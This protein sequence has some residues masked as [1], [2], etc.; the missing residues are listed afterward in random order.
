MGVLIGKWKWNEIIFPAYGIDGAHHVKFVCNGVSYN[1]ILIYSYQ[2]FYRLV[3]VPAE[4]YQVVM[5]TS[6]MRNGIEEQ[7]RIIDV[8]SSDVSDS[9]Y[10]WFTEN[11]TRFKNYNVDFYKH[12]TV[13]EQASRLPKEL[14]EAYKKSQMDRITIFDGNA[15]LEVTG[16]AEYSY[17]DEKSYKT[18]PIRNQDGSIQ[19]IEEYATFLTPRAIIKYSM[20]KIEDYR[21]I[22]KMLKSR[23]ALIVK[24]YD[25][26]E[27]KI[28]RNEMYVAPPSMPKIYQQYLMALGIQEYSLELIGTNVPIL[29]SIDGN[30]TREIDLRI[31]HDR[32]TANFGMVWREWVQYH[33]DEYYV[34]SDG[35]IG[36]SAGGFV[37]PNLSSYVNAE[38]YIL[39]H[40][41]Y[42]L[43]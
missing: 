27:D 39:E 34:T 41:I 24:C 17:L 37:A 9:L 10:N 2:I 29:P 12:R 7:Y 5:A 18:Q 25:V 11:A 6:D 40:G 16:F 42:L 13:E 23:N 35:R 43:N 3:G 30:S 31:V 19:D 4:Q 38:D 21:S 26:V 36:A 28:V 14:R 33:S 22:M 15:E 1:E 32:Y 8:E 20:M